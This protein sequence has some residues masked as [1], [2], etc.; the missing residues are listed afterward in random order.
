MSFA[1]V[2]VGG[3]SSTEEVG[4]GAGRV[5]GQPAFAVVYAQSPGEAPVTT[6]GCGDEQ[7]SWPT[8]E[9]TAPDLACVV[10]VGYSVGE[11]IDGQEKVYGSIP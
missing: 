5:L 7:I 10:P 9:R 3:Q 2:M 6:V 4:P 8:A 11:W 1:A